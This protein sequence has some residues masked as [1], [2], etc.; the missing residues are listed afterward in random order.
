HGAPGRR[1]V[2][3]PPAFTAAGRAVGEEE[4]LVLTS[5]GIDIGS[6]TTHLNFSRL[7]LKRRDSRY[8]VIE[9]VSL[10]ESAIALTPLDPGDRQRIDG[11]ALGAFFD[12][13]YERAGLRRAGIDTGALILTGLAVRRQNARQIAKLFADE[14][15]KFVTVTA[16]DGLEATMAAYGSGAVG[17]PGTCLNVDI[18]GGTTK[19][20]LCGGGRVLAV[21]AI[22]VG[23]R[24][25]V[26]DTDGRLAVVEPA[27]ALLADALQLKLQPGEPVD[28]PVLEELVEAMT[29]VIFA[30]AAQA[31][32]AV[33]EPAGPLIPG[34]LDRLSRLPVLPASAA[35][36]DSVVFSGGVS[37]YVYEREQASFGDLGAMI[38]RSVRRRFAASGIAVTDAGA[39]IRATAM[40]ASQY[41]VQVS[42]STIFVDPPSVLPLRG[43]PVASL[44]LGLDTPEIDPA[45]V[46]DRV[47]AA[48]VRA[49]GAPGKPGEKPVAVAVRWEGS[50]TYGRLDGLTAG[51]EAGLAAAPGVPLVIISQG[52]VGGLIGMHIREAGRVDNPVVSI[53]GIELRDFDYVDVGS[54]IPA[55]GAVPVVIKSIV[56]PAPGSPLGRLTG[57]HPAWELLN[58]RASAGG[59]GTDRPPKVQNA[60]NGLMRRAAARRFPPGS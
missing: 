1:R 30:A 10:Y 41:T 25:L 2:T 8:E 54:L 27:A 29:A 7:V 46:A 24:L 48:L 36:P 31:G 6:S 21:T 55:S 60:G 44:D 12:R 20:A 42:G 17:Q 3:V 18:G 5:V 38:A 23:A 32:Q 4:E 14:A 43:V 40:G 22:D 34:L 45:E 49:A 59:Q 35:R 57:R 56:F 9:R 15:G 53:D 28:A 26:F 51:L 11:A 50:A 52:D 19:F 58:E 47:R 13:E 37:E 39:G 16:G 33:P